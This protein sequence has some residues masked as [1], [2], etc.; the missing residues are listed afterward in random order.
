MYGVLRHNVMAE[1][2]IK[3]PNNPRPEFLFIQKV[4]TI[5]NHLI[6]IQIVGRTILYIQQNWSD[7]LTKFLNNVQFLH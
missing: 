7:I 4:E 5:F 1:R 6:E 2:S 3:P